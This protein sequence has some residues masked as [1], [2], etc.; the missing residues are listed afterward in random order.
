MMQNYVIIE[1]IKDKSKN[2]IYTIKKDDHPYFLKK[3][4]KMKDIHKAYKN[5]REILKMLNHENIIKYIDSFE[6]YSYYYLITEYIKGDD[7]H[8]H[9][10]NNSL[11]LS[12]IKYI[13]YETA[14]AIKY[15][16]NNNITHGDIKLE[17]IM[18][19]DNFKTIKLIDFGLS[20][21][22]TNKTYTN[23]GTKYYL[24]PEYFS[25]SKIDLSKCDIWA[26]GVTL[27]I[28]FF[29]NHPFDDDT[30]IDLFT[31]KI[32]NII[33]NNEPTYVSSKMSII[34]PQ[35]IDLLKHIFIKNPDDRCNIDFILEH[36]WFSD[37]KLH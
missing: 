10:C 22:Y 35:I 34:C 1:E 32:K 15:L 20:K 33:C 26:Y 12:N 8:T 37:T 28:I 19:S 23:G 29:D 21:K 9:Y 16:H 25:R 3:I 2:A 18:I 6:D 31:E 27:Y 17:N 5:E 7:L 13:F 36:I 14:R 30:S 4:S 24:S 11:N